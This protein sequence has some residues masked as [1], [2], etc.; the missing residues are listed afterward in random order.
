VSLTFDDGRAAAYP[1]RSILSSHGMH[2]TFYLNSGRVGTNNYYM[3]WPQI[4]DLAA[5]GN[6]IGGHTV[7]HTVLTS[8]TADQAMH[9]VCDDRATLQA[10]GYNPVS[11]AYPEIA[12]NASVQQIV[13]DCGYTSARA[14]DAQMQGYVTS[15]ENSGGG[16]V[17]FMFDSVWTNCGT[18]LAVSPT[19]LSA[20]LDWLGRARPTQRW[21]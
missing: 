8:L 2:G 6:E 10:H 18:T 11:F 7:D 4:A 13:R 3:T 12:Y 20:L 17:V 14:G 16:W 15:V 21:S 5:H 1:A 19:N 9:A